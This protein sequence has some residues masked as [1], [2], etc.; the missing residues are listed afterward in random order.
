MKYRLLTLL[1]TLGCS[2]S[3]QGGSTARS[4]PSAP[5]EPRLANIRMLTNGGENAEA[6]FSADDKRLIFQKTHPPELPC[7]QI[8][9]MKLDGSDM[10]RISNGQ[11]RTTCGY[12]HPGRDRAV[13]ASTHHT[14]AACP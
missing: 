1:L 6:Y 2:V 13:Y 7:D 14:G 10:R 3:S 8:F 12:F 5:D 4:Y 9:S 11:G